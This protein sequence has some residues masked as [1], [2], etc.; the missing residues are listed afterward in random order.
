MD[1]FALFTLVFWTYVALLVGAAFF[2][3]WRFVI[4]NWI[5]LGLVG[6]FAVAAVA[7]PVRIDWLL[8]LGAMA[9]MLV[10][11]LTLYRFRL[12]GGGDLKL[13]VAVS[14]WVGLDALPLLLFWI[15]IA[16]GAFSLGLIALRRT[17]VGALVAQSA[18]TTV[19]LPRVLLP[20]EQIPYGVAI[21]A[22][23]VWV[24]RGLPHLGLF[25]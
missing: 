12:L 18:F 23:G 8:H 10:A 25:A 6:L 19:T 11:T 7:L 24:A 21:A 4:P 16:G 3:A 2:D 15:A 14:L 1:A 17:L 9:L 13:L 5:V 20:G 22:G